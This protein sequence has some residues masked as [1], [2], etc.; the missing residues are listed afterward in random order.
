[1]TY[2]PKHRG[3]PVVKYRI[4]VIER[5]RGW[6][7]HE[8]TEDFDTRRQAHTRI[9]EINSQNPP[10]PAPDF[11]TQAEHEIRRVVL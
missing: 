1:M 6:G 9:H 8:W 10:G 7:Q 5:E 11:Y 2:Q 4:T 3:E